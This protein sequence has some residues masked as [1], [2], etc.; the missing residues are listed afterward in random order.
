MAAE[1]ADLHAPPSATLVKDRPQ[2]RDKRGRILGDAEVR[3]V[4]MIVRPWRLPPTIEIQPV[5]WLT[6][7]TIGVRGIE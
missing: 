5:V 7:T 1:T 3:P 6:L 2:S 4:K